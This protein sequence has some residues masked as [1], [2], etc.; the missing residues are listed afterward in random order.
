MRETIED[1][2]LGR[3]VYDDAGEWYE[4]KAEITPGHQALV[5][6]CPDEDTPD[7]RAAAAVAQGTLARLRAADTELRRAAATELV[8]QHPDQV[9]PYTAEAVAAELW[10]AVVYFWADGGARIDWDSEPPLLDWNSCNWATQ[11][12]PAGRVRQSDW[13]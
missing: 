2:V 6:V 12:D 7:G 3:L 4:G 13:E 5:F 11:V 9:A 1:P 10:A 8:A